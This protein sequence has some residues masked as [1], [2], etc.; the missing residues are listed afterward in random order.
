M[1]SFVVYT[2]Q[3]APLFDDSPNLFPDIYPSV[4]SVWKNKQKIFSEVYAKIA[5]S[6]R[7]VKYEHETIYNENGIIVFRIANN[8]HVT[9]ESS[10][11]TKRLEH[12]P[13]CY[14][15]VDNRI[16]V[17]SILIEDDSYSFSDPNVVSKILQN[18]FN[19]Y[20]KG[21]G[22]SIE[23]KK[24]YKSDEFWKYVSSV[25]EPI[26][27]LRFSFLYPNLPRVQET[28]DKALVRSSKLVQSKNTTIEY[29]SGTNE[30]LNLSKENLELI[31]LVQAASISGSDIKLRVGSF[32]RIKTIGESTE[33]VE[34]NN[35]EAEL[36]P[37]LLSSASQ[38]L[39]AILNKF[40]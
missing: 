12:H 13:S 32:R 20:L 18:S 16:D 17:Q 10:F 29:N 25:K 23:I 21:Y 30:S 4:E 14:V 19:R 34:I 39:I 8:R 40:K 28:I 27:M 37:D 3:F 11:V 2:Y 24:R 36:T 1:P 15:I 5:F 33:I 9:Q 22:L 7:N 35:L 31:R 6:N 26:R 38:K